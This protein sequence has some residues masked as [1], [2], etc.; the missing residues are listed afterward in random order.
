VP[1]KIL[2]K[3]LFANAFYRKK[4]LAMVCDFRHTSRSCG[5]NHSS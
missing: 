1:K 2:G 4:K 5:D 3:Q